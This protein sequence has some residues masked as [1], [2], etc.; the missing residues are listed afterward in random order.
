MKIAEILK[1]YSVDRVNI[2]S[3]GIMTVIPIV[4]NVEFT[5]VANVNEVCLKADR[6]YDKLEFKNSSGHIGIALQGWAIM[7]EQ[8]AQD[9]TIPYGHLVKGQKSKLIPANCIQRAQGGLFD[10][11]KWNQENFTVLPPS[12]RG[13][14]LKKA[15]YTNTELGALW[16]PLSS[17][18]TK[19][20]CNSGLKCFYDKYEKNLNTFV[21]QFE[22]VDNQLGA[23]VLINGEIVAIDIMPKY[24]SW[25]AVWRAYIRDSYGAEAIRIADAGNTSIDR[26]VIDIDKVETLSDLENSFSKVKN[27]FYSTLETSFNAVAQLNIETKQLEQI[28]ELTMLKLDGSGYIGQGVLHGDEHFV[29]LSLVNNEEVA[30]KRPK[31][32]SLRSNPYGS[33]SFSFN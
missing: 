19:V 32:Q 28:D 14:A 20:D 27:D 29:Y 11:T 33:G 9:R 16:D 2:Q 1:G 23:V 15:S 6:S 13:I 24:D 5:N 25:K 7:D 17:W 31:F 22:P 3:A 8:P 18:A 12:L 4:S 10:V 26:F 30:K 21:A